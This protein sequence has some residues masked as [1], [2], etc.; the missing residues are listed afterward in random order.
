MLLKG[1]LLFALVT[2]VDLRSGGGQDQ[3][4]SEP[5]H[6][7]ELVVEPKGRGDDGEALARCCHNGQLVAVVQGD[8]QENENLAEGTAQCNED[9]VAQQGQIS[10]DSLH[11]RVL[12]CIPSKGKEN[13]VASQTDQV[14]VEHGVVGVGPVFFGLMVFVGLRVDEAIEEQAHADEHDAEWAVISEATLHLTYVKDNE[15]CRN[16]QGDQDL[17]SLQTIDTCEPACQD[18]GQ[19]FG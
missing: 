18:D 1:L 8:R 10:Q 4:C 6:I 16:S 17:A 9:H 5:L 3:G 7:G 19:D 14:V 13:S 12:L 2:E 11:C 15:A